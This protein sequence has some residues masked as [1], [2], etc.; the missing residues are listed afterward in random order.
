MKEL[1]AFRPTDGFAKILRGQL[2]KNPICPL[3][4]SFLFFINNIFKNFLKNLGAIGTAN[5]CKNA[6]IL[7]NGANFQNFRRL[8]RQNYAIY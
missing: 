1:S 3:S 2:I 6:V 7:Q 8:R 4:M 5:S